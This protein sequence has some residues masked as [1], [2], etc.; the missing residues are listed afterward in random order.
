MPAPSTSSLRLE[1]PCRQRSPQDSR[2]ALLS[3]PQPA[4]ALAQAA[5]ACR[6][7]PSQLSAAARPPVAGAWKRP[8]FLEAGP[9]P[10]LGMAPIVLPSP[11]TLTGS[12]GS[13][14]HKR[15]AQAAG[16]WGHSA[17]QGRPGRAGA[18]SQT[19]DRPLPSRSSSAPPSLPLNL[20][21]PVLSLS[22]VCVSVPTC[23]SLSLV[24]AHRNSHSLFSGKCSHLCKPPVL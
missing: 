15:A 7:C 23:L 1:Q 20:C 2:L 3:A 5:S 13:L 11:R 12:P 16:L 21:V 19:V 22:V 24:S 6:T 4:L 9:V 8:G 10:A 18:S 14:V 17:A